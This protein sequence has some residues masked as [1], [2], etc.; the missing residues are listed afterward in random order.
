MLET[1]GCGGAGVSE[2]KQAAAAGSDGNAVGTDPTAV[3]LALAGA[4]RE[5]ADAFLDDQRHHLNEQFKHL[6]EQYK[7]LRLRTWEKRLGVLPRVATAVIGISV[8]AALAF[9]VWDAA[10]SN[11]SALLVQFLNDQSRR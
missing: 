9:I 7:Q 3:A 11:G 2:S 4:S 10:Q 8:A 5:K 1:Q 6:A